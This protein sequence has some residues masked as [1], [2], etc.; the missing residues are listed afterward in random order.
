M[1]KWIST[2]A[3]KS[4]RGPTVPKWTG[5]SIHRVLGARFLERPSDL[6]L[7]AASSWSFLPECLAQVDNQCLE[8]QYLLSHVVQ[9]FTNSPGDAFYRFYACLVNGGCGDTKSSANDRKEVGRHQLLV[10]RFA[11]YN[12]SALRRV[13]LRAYTCVCIPGG[14]TAIPRHRALIVVL[15]SP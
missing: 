15:G 13:S 2:I 6:N 7:G 3:N 5:L 10:Q 12:R 9:I 1:A 8:E 4:N 14:S 11:L